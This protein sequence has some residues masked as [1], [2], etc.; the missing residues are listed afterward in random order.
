MPVFKISDT[1]GDP[2][3]NNNRLKFES[4][5]QDFNPAETFVTQTIVLQNGWN[6]VGTYID[7]QASAAAGVGTF[8]TGASITNMLSSLGDNVIFAKDFEGSAYLPD[9]GYDGVGLIRNGYGYLV[10]VGDN[11]MGNSG[12]FELTIS[13][14]PIVL[15]ETSQFLGT[16]QYY[17]C[18]IQFPEGWFN[19]TIPFNM[20]NDQ[21]SG[22]GN[23]DVA[24]VLDHLTD[25][26][27][28]LITI[29]KD[30]QGSAFLPEW[31]FNGVGDFTAGQSYQIKSNSAWTGRFTGTLI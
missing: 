13:G 18:E 27:I 20:Q 8:A 4:F 30:F 1:E 10:K 16:V 23:Y 17:G 14:R 25:G 3:I 19:F 28:S 12:T 31:N 2:L 26:Q 21:L 5:V 29:L 6:F 7:A 11:I 15:E 9:Y 24:T 22:V